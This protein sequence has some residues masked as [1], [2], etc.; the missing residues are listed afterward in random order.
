MSRSLLVIIT[1]IVVGIVFSNALTF[2][3]EMNV[4][5]ANTMYSVGNNIGAYLKDIFK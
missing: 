5:M 2:L 3:I 4:Q 1:F